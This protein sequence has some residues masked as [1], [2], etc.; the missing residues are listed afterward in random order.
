MSG[1][2]RAAR[3]FLVCVAL[4]ALSGISGAQMS[5]MRGMAA[6]TLITSKEVQKELKFTG[7]QAKKLQDKQKEMMNAG[8][9]K[10]AANMMSMMAVAAS[11]DGAEKWLADLLSPEQAKRYHELILQYQGPRAFVE[12]S[13][14]KDLEFS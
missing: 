13:V 2:H 11:T 3:M 4:T 1:V 9:S 14:A 10:D 6:M 8:K 7:D 5:M 12:P